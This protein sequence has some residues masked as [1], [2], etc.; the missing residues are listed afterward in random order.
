MKVVTATEFKAK[1]L[2]LL[3][4]VR[5]GHESITITK[6]GEPVA[7]VS[8]VKKRRFKSSAGSWKGRIEEV[9]DIV[10]FSMWDPDAGEI[11]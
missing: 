4:E 9:G 5:E 2:S 1:C 10:H 7:V 3:E 11:K 6:R 8:P